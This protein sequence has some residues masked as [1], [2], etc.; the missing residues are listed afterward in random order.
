MLLLFAALFLPGP[1]APASAEERPDEA[2]RVAALVG[3][4]IDAYGGREAIEGVRSFHL[5]GRIRAALRGKEGSYELYAKQ[6]RKLFVEITYQDATAERRILNGDRGYRGTTTL[7]L[8]EVR[9]PRY[10]AMVYQYKHL[11]ALND[12]V[13]GAYRVRSRGADAAYSAMRGREVEVL[14]FADSDGAVI[15]AYVDTGTFM[16]IKVAGHFKADGKETSLSAE[17]DDF[18]QV[19]GRLFPFRITNFAGGLKIGETTVERYEIN[20]DIPDSLFT[21][22]APARL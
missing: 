19:G 13:K 16:I 6:E 11:T 8:E 4:V 10:L 9:G 2:Q 1:A 5:K 21:P 15:D 3:R 17:F 20:P 14:T 22:S 18:R 7:P 12:I